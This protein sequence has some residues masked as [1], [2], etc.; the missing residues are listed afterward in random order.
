MFGLG[1]IASRAFN[2]LQVIVTTTPSTWG[3]KGGLGKKKKEEHLKKS[4]RADLKEY[5]ATVFEEPVAQELKEE[6]KEYIKPKQEL[7]VATVNYS[8]LEKNIDLINR[9]IAKVQEIEQEQEDEAVL[10]MLM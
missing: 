6:V 9:I 3:Q 5:L 8:K 7:S 4:H 1:A 10:L 2:T